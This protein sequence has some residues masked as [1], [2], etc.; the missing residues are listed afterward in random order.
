ME[1]EPGRT[2]RGVAAPVTHI[3]RASLWAGCLERSGSWDSGVERY[4]FIQK[5]ERE[6]K[7]KEKWNPAIEGYL[8]RTQTSA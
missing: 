1:V 4:T 5:D 7:K 6:K 2:T 8:S 3:K